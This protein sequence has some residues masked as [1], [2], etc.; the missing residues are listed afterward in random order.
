MNLLTMAL[1]SL[2]KSAP[3]VPKVPKVPPTNAST[4]APAPAPAPKRPKPFSPLS[5]AQEEAMALLSQAVTYNPR[6]GT[7]TWRHSGKGR[8]PGAIAGCIGHDGYVKLSVTLRSGKR[9][10]VKGH[11]LAI[12]IMHNHNQCPPLQAD[13]KVW[14][15]DGDRANCAWDNLGIDYGDD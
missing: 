1:A 6:N 4:P 13:T 9:A 15:V 5:P 14:Q 11:R 3:K 12:Y 2:I 8:T 10:D 7:F